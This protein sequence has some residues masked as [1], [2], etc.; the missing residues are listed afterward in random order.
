MQDNNIPNCTRNAVDTQK[1]YTLCDQIYPL[2]QTHTHDTRTQTHT[3]IQYYK[4]A[5]GRRRRNIAYR[6]QSTIRQRSSA[7]RPASFFFFY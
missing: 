4:L 6:L 5:Q 1:L 2:Q 7:I 3:H